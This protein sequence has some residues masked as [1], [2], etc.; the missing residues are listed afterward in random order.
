[1]KQ[2]YVQTWKNG[3]GAVQRIKIKDQRS[4]DDPFSASVSHANVVAALSETA[5]TTMRGSGGTLVVT[6]TPIDGSLGVALN[7]NIGGI[8][9][10]RGRGIIRERVEEHSPRCSRGEGRRGRPAHIVA[11]ASRTARTHSTVGVGGAPIGCSRL[12]AR[13]A[14]QLRCRT[15]VVSTCTAWRVLVGDRTHRSR[16]AD[17]GCHAAVEDPDTDRMREGERTVGQSCDL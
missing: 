10:G 1:C 15:R 12:G 16:F 2:G 9:T 6:E 8:G 13:N 11:T 14:H 5:E 3:V 17:V 4:G 7:G